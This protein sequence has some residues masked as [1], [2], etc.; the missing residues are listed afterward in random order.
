MTSIFGH[1]GLKPIQL[2]CK[3]EFLKGFR[4]PRKTALIY[5]YFLNFRIDIKKAKFSINMNSG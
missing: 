2:R 1:P 5:Y 3:Q 4:L